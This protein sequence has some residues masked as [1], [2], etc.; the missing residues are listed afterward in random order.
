MD[1]L[2]AAEPGAT[3]LL[4][5]PFDPAEVWNHLPRAVQQTLIEK[6]LKFFVID[7]YAVARDTGM[8]NRINTIMQTC[9]FAISGVL[10][11]EEAINEIKKAIRETYGKRGEAVIEKN[12]A[13]V[14]HALAAFASRCGPA[15]RQQWLRCTPGGA[16][17]VLR[18]SFAT[19][20]ADYRAAMEMNCRSALCRWT[21]HS[22]RRRLGGRSAISRSK[23]LCG[24]KIFAF[25]AEN[26]CWFARTP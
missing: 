23:F 26:A 13:A 21:G 6:Q 2:A 4:N 14:D 12:F 20:W 17:A 8:G 15:T 3:F 1:V 19:F 10:P 18:G 24:T 11:R 5:S 22:R 7:G 25:N 16:G 9:F